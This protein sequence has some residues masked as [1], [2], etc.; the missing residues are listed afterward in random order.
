MGLVRVALTFDTEVPPRPSVPGV[1]ERVLAT[2][3]DAGVRAT[4]FLQGL[5]ARSN[6]ALACAI[7][8]AGHLI[9]SHSYYHAPMDLFTEEGFRLDVQTAEESIREVT[10]VDPRPWFRCPFGSGKDDPLVLQRLADL[11]YRHVG[12]HISPHD[13]LE[14]RSA[15][16]VEVR[17]LKGAAKASGDVIV[18]LHSWP[19]ATA[20]ALPTVLERLVSRGDEL[21]TVE[22]IARVGHEAGVISGTR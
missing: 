2:L 7:A 11:G 14:G 4:F 19:T 12:W 10:S 20:D 9:G 3:A 22:Q 21:V 8:E 13:W 15:E 17:I 1:E 5:W 6:P 18:L 16:R